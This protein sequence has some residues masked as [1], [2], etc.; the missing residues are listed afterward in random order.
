MSF[1]IRHRLEYWSA[2]VLAALVRLLPLRLGWALGAI[3]GQLAF[4]IVRVRRRVTMENLHHAFSESRSHRELTKI[5]AR[6]YRNLGRGLVEFCRFPSLTRRNLSRILE[7]E[8]LEHCTRGLAQGKGVII[9][10]GHFGAWELLSP[11]FG[12]LVSRHRR[13]VGIAIHRIGHTPWGVV[14]SLRRNRLVIIL[15]DQ[16]GGRDGIFIPFLGRLAST[17]RGAA[18]FAMET[19]ATVLMSFVVRQPGNRHRLI[20]HPAMEIPRSCNREEDLFEILKTYTQ[21]LETYVRIYPEQWFWPHRRWKSRPPADDP[22]A[23]T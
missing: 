23:P 10:S 13:Q 2:R 11:A 4:S 1:P 18:R 6:C 16:D 5:G 9:L 7:I 22:A 14:R 20:I 21:C 3:L 8:G 15:A 19:G 17:A 12:L